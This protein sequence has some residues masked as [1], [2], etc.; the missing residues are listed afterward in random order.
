MKNLFKIEK[1]P[2]MSEVE[3]S[4]KSKIKKEDRTKVSRSQ[5][6]MP[7]LRYVFDDNKIEYIESMAVLLLNRHN[8]VIGWAKISQGGTSGTV[9]DPKVVFQLALNT[10][11]SGIILCHNHPSG[12]L[13]AS[14]SDIALST[15]IK[16]GAK[17]LDLQLLDH[18]IIT[19][20]SHLSMADEGLF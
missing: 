14:Q 10:N 3:L 1:M 2:L 4:Y 17:I 9:C 19:A 16:Q 11:A 6:C 20:E 13:Q 7:L 8:E 5:D 15:K 18:I 12:N